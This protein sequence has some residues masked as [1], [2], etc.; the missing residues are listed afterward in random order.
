MSPSDE[1]K[2]ITSVVINK[3]SESYN[4]VWGGFL[5]SGERVYDV[6]L[7]DGTLGTILARL[8]GPAYE[9]GWRGCTEALADGAIAAQG[10]SGALSTCAANWR[11]AE[12]ASMVR[13]R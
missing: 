4:D 13:Y 10:I 11:A 8:I 6:A 2:V 3:M 7:D 12:E 5:R 9:T 1:T